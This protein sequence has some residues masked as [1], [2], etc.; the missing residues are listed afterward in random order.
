MQPIIVSLCLIRL[1]GCTLHR[2]AVTPAK[3]NI[4]LILADDLG[5]GHVSCF[6]PQSLIK[7]P[8]IDRL[9][10]QGTGFIDVHTPTSV[11]TP[12]RRSETTRWFS[13]A[14]PKRRST[15]A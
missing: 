5:H 12:A 10:T 14:I 2:Q 9:A 15:I 8:H 6:N 7:T 4:V 11:C 1:S 13:Y 3:P